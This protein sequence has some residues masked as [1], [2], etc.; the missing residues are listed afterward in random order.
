MAGVNG[1]LA[2]GSTDSTELTGPLVDPSR[3]WTRLDSSPQVAKLSTDFPPLLV[4]GLHLE[5]RALVCLLV[6]SPESPCELF[7]RN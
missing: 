5:K 7:S 2:E 6:L 4:Q 1:S 3:M